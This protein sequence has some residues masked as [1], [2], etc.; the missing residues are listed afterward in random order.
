MAPA[1]PDNDIDK[2][3]RYW[4]FN[5]IKNMSK[6]D[7]ILLLDNEGYPTHA[8]TKLVLQRCAERLERNLPCY[9][10]C[11][12]EELQKFIQDRS[13]VP[14]VGSFQRSNSIVALISADVHA[15]FHRF[16]DLAPE[17][18]VMV[19]EY[20][21]ADLPKTLQC[22]V[23]PPM[24]RVSS[25][26]RTEV[27]PMFCSQT[28]FKFIMCVHGTGQL[29]FDAD[30]SSFLLGL[31]HSEG[32]LVRSVRLLVESNISGLPGHHMCLEATVSEDGLNFNVQAGAMF[33]GDVVVVAP[34]DAAT[35]KRLRKMQRAINTD[36]RGVL[37]SVVQGGKKEGLKMVDI[38]ALRSI[39]EKAWFA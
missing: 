27:L 33:F 13:I 21:L 23:Q 22:P 5:D 10:R 4:R 37:K 36:A 19:Y 3:D 32:M 14:P 20:Y 18:R 17:L 15:T 7:L 6:G 1:K 11:S 8:C 34:L 2:L 35:K 38:Y 9:Y 39:L 30:A 31:G 25:Q 26:T 28:K 24:S 12:N 29:R 16:M